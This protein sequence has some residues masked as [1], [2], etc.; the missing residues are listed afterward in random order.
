MLKR[1]DTIIVTC[2]LLLSNAIGGL[3]G[4]IITTALP[5]IVSDLHGIEL[6]GWVLAVFLLATAV[7]TPLWSKLGEYI[8]NKRAYMISTSIFALGSLLQVLA[9]NMVFLIAARTVMGLGGGGM[10]GLPFIIYADLYKDLDRR[11]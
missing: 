6:M 11:A 3:D 4:T 8:G 5:A 2:A 10:N 1:R 9:P 7:T